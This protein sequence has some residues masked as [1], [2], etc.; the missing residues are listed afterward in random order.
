VK[1]RRLRQSGIHRRGLDFE[2]QPGS[3]RKPHLGPET[4]ET[5]P[6][7]RFDAPEVEGVPDAEPLRVAPAQ[8]HAD[9][10][11]DLVDEATEAPQHVRHRP[12]RRSAD[13]LDLGKDPLGRCRDFSD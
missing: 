10:P 13:A 8:A 11:K 9:T 3:S 5:G 7:Q 6:I 1:V 4:E 12:T 2:L